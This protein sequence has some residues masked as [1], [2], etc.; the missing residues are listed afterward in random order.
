MNYI[1]ATY[2]NINPVVFY[3]GG[4][5]CEP[6]AQAKNARSLPTENVDYEKLQYYYHPDHLGSAS[7]ITNLDG[8]VVQH[9]EYVPFGEVF[10]EERNNTW[11]T[12]FLFNGKELDEETG[13]YYYGARYYNP[14]IS[15]WYGVDPLTEKYIGYSPY[16]FSGNN[17]IRYYDVDGRYFDERNERKASRIEKKALK[18]A[19]KL[20]AKVDKLILKGQDR[21]E[22]CDRADELRKSV[23]DIQEMRNDGTT[24]YRYAKVDS[25]AAKRNNIIG[26]TAIPTG[27]NSEGNNVITLFTE[28]GMGSVLHETRHGGDIARGSLQFNLSGGYG[29]SHEISAYRAQYSW[30][31]S[32]E[33]IPF[34]NFGVQTNLTRLFREGISSFKVDI[35]NLNQITPAMVNSLVDKPG[36][37]QILIYPPKDA[38]GRILI[39]ISIWNSN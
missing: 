14:R 26:P 8:E 13:L 11:N 7:Y 36:L 21:G 28:K 9:V 6:K 27:Q 29:I 32:F 20:E 12:P 38:N 34:T 3:G 18:R 10:L 5:C 15:L 31:G 25:R 2:S 39:P 22:L 24:E 30:D 35:T 37:N 1:A 16:H 4:F 33:Y 19:E 17:P 23:N